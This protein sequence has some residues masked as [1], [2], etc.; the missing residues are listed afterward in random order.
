MRQLVNILLYPNIK[1]A[2]M[3]KMLLLLIVLSFGINSAMAAKK[4]LAGGCGLGTMLFKENTL[5]HQVLAATT[6]GSSGNQTFGMSTGTLGCEVSDV[7][8]RTAQT[9]FIQANKVALSNDVARGKGET[10]AT[11]TQMYGCSNVNTVGPV[12]RKNYKEIFP[13]AKTPADQ[14]NTK[15]STI[16][17]NSKVCIN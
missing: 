8:K 5:L 12:L 9:V 13:N 16:L 4:Y 6:N 14:I 10:L 15:I 2:I 1:G 11:L 7:K 3:K 17:N